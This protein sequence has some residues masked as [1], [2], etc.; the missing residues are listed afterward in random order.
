MASSASLLLAHH[1]EGRR[2]LVV[3][4]GH[5]ARVRAQAARDAGA[6]PVVVGATEAPP[7]SLD[8]YAWRSVP[9]DVL[10]PPT[11]ELGASEAA[12]TRLLDELDGP[13]AALFAVCVTDTLVLSSDQEQ[14]DA[15]HAA[16]RRS[17]LLRT[18]CRKRRLLLNVTDEP[19]LCDFS[20]PATHRFAGADG[21]ASSLQLAVATTGHGCRLAGRIRRAAVEALP[22]AVGAAVDRVGELRALAKGAGASD[23]NGAHHTG[24]PLL[25]GE[26]EDDPR[27]SGATLGYTPAEPSSHAEQRRRMQWV[28]QISEYWPLERLAAL[29][30][31][32]MHALL[33]EYS[34]EAPA[35]ATGAQAEGGAAE[36]PAKRSRH[37]LPVAPPPGTIYLLGSG[38]GHPALLTVAAHRLLTSPATDV[39]LSDKLVPTAVLALIPRDKSL[40]IAKKFPGNAE[41]AQSELIAQALE[42]A[43][44]GKTV[45]RLKQGDPFVYGRGGEELLAFTRAGLHCSVVPG[46]SSALAG[47][48]MFGVPATQRGAADSVALCTGVGRGGKRVSLPGYERGRTL[49]ILMG[50]ARLRA[51]IDTLTD[52]HAGADV[53]QGAAY[54]GCTPI[55]IVERASSS[56]QRMIASTLDGIA[57][58]IEHRLPDGPR[59]PNMMV[60]G[61]AVLSL[62]GDTA[63]ARVLDDEAELQDAAAR[64]ERTAEQARSE[65]HQRDLARVHGWLGEQGYTIHEGLPPG[66]KALDALMEQAAEPGA[67]APPGECAADPSGVPRSESGWAASRYGDRGPTGGWTPQEQPPRQGQS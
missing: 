50:V 43:R 48:L 57:E 15:V 6:E 28:A 10:F 22:A 32:A 8:S 19:A 41:G 14:A 13:D 36:P 27:V 42:A 37:E 33:A 7:A 53:R 47:P 23:A 18:L 30:T 49:L 62:A 34:A 4:T 3:G 24:R 46:I 21:R 20:F 65:L 38:P 64:G 12:W 39:I 63:G 5:L 1:A 51:V 2:I 40:V 67:G 58:V 59:P 61:W 17:R 45:V 16:I 56:D 11:E 31:P 60:V 26:L 29:D 66:Y 25:G 35:A 9:H 52:V 44:A 54:P 55:A